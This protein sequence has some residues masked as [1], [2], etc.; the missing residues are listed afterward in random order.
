LVLLAY[1][2]WRYFKL[3]AQHIP[4]AEDKPARPV[5]ASSPLRGLQSHT[6]RIG[7]LRLL[8]IAVKVVFSS[9]RNQVRYSIHDARTPTMIGFLRFLGRL[10]LRPWQWRVNR[11]TGDQLVGA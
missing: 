2:I 8:L 7:R 11:K 10:R 3:V 5:A 4:G 9:N 1:N 6:N